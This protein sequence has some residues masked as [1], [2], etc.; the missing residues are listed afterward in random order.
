MRLDEITI[1]ADHHAT[2]YVTHARIRRNALSVQILW[3]Y[4]VKGC[5]FRTDAELMTYE[6]HPEM[7]CLHDGDGWNI[8]EVKDLVAG[9]VAQFPDQL[10]T[11]AQTTH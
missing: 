3:G 11:T 9:S 10:P 8:E 4:F 1:Q 6:D 7:D 2:P 5:F